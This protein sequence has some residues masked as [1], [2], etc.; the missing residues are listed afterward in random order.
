MAKSKRLNES[1]EPAKNYGTAD[2]EHKLII[3][4]NTTTNLAAITPKEV[5]S[6]AYDTTLSKVVINNGSSFSPIDNN[7]GGTV[8]SVATGSG[9][10]GG[11]ITTTGTVSLADTAVT[12]GSYT[13][14]NITIDTTASN[15]STPVAS[16]R[17]VNGATTVTTADNTVLLSYETVSGNVTLPAGTNGLSF[18]LAGVGAYT[19]SPNYTL[20]PN[21]SDTFDVNL[22][23]TAITPGI[24]RTIVFL[25]GVWY[26]KAN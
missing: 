16:V 9:L 24:S 4:Q 19:A 25:S 12:P 23:P 3:P 20:I 8:T 21:G 26:I 5:G 14:A 1:Q 7:S 6:L 22:D 15:G 18:T 11:P 2:N 10:T 17:L 13:N